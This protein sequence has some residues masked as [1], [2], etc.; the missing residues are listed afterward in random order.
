M[1]SSGIQIVDDFLTPQEQQA[2]WLYVLQPG[3]SFG[4]F[5]DNGPMG[6]RYFYK[7][8]AGYQQDGREART[9]E[10][11]EAELAGHATRSAAA[12]PT[13]CRRAPRAGCT[14]IPTSIPT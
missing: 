13:A 3:W 9:P 7:H 6:S 5:S 12:T 8:Y 10:A 2:V 11:I 14:W 4:A 1:Q